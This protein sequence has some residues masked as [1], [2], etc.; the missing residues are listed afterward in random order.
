MKNFNI[1]DFL[2]K[3]IIKYPEILLLIPVVIGVI[4]L[5]TKQK[6]LET[7]KNKRVGNNQMGSSRFM[8]EKD[9]M[10]YFKKIEYCPNQW[11]KNPKSRPEQGKVVKNSLY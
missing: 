4:I 11:R 10:K 2:I 8:N 1:F 6:N 9:K 5:S 3:L 7:I